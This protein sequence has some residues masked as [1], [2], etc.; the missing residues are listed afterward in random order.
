MDTIFALATARARAGVAVVRISGPA[1]FEAAGQL[2]SALPAPGQVGYRKIVC[3]DRGLIDQGLV[4]TF[5]GPAS[6]TGEDTVEFQVH[7]SI[8]VISALEAAIE[9]TGLARPAEAGEFTRRALWNERMDLAQV[10]ALGDLIEAETEQQRLAAQGV[11]DGGLTQM[12]EAV[13]GDL[14]RARALL[15]ATIDFAD[16]DVPVDVSGEVNALLDRVEA[17]LR[18][19]IAG[20]RIAE[21][22][23]HGFEVAIVGA[24]NVGKSTL[25]NQIAGREVAISSE[26]AG[27]TRDVLEV[28]VDLAGLPVTFL[29][30][31]GLRDTTDRIE[32]LG[33]ERARL[34]AKHADLRVFLVYDQAEVDVALRQPEDLVVLAKADM[35][36]AVAGLAVSGKTGFGVDDLLA[37]VQKALSDRLVGVGF[38][39]R[40]RHRRALEGALDALMSARDGL[41]GE[42]DVPEL[43]AGHL[44]ETGRHLDVLIGRLDV[45][46]ILGEIFSKFCIGK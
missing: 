30:T 27:T 41:V 12:A 22:L 8:A 35:L 44:L 36:Q 13:R 5:K 17:A 10:E 24:P 7:G 46:E 18:A 4:L 28:R 39:N 31:A 20:S 6:F 11:L 32:A 3:G 25:L 29:D 23:R 33:V 19:E 38:A 34:R 45:E 37:S 43:V 9:A 26:I 16:E 14:L 1:A 21:R 2:V 40:E 15:E 42:V